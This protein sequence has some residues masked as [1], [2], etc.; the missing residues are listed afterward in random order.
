MSAD[1][2]LEREENALKDRFT[3]IY[4]GKKAIPFGSSAIR[5]C[6]FVQKYRRCAGTRAPQI[7]ETVDGRCAFGRYSSRDASLIPHK[8]GLSRTFPKV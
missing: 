3:P 6:Y 1:L 4:S 7:R 2:S 8:A 5:I